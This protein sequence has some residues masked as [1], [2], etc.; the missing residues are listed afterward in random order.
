MGAER[1]SARTV[2][3]ELSGEL[4]RLRKA[5][6]LT[7][8]ALARRTSYSKSSW[9]RYLNAK[10]LPPE[11]AVTAFAEAT[12][13]PP[14]SLLALRALAERSAGAGTEQGDQERPE[15]ESGDG[16]GDA[17]AGVRGD[18]QSEAPARARGEARGDA[19]T[20][21]RDEAPAQ[22]PGAGRSGG[23]AVTSAQ[24]E[25]PAPAPGTE[26]TPGPP[27]R[28]RRRRWPWAAVIGGVAALSF[29]AGFVAG[30]LPTG[31]SEAA[32]AGDLQLPGCTDFE[33]RSKD[34]QRLGC[35]VGVWT[36]AAEKVDGAYVELRWSPA[37]RAAWA[38]VTDAQVGDVARVVGPDGG[39][40]E[41]AI[42][43]DSDTYSPM[44]E[45]PYPAAV[46]ACAELLDGREICTRQGGASPLPV[47]PEDESVRDG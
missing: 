17:Q 5:S 15:G 34:P 22:T 21:T 45:A 32:Q 20:G 2:A 41:R 16:R 7:L 3:P 6:G 33:C 1:R 29:A 35:H 26:V 23:E 42:S 10:A 14:E 27:P 12:G 46:R 43:Y 8:A 28:A 31:S 38:R 18:A 39:T 13:V 9:E 44:V 11:Q 40:Q 36:A 24:A 37:C 25:V 30:W 19:P 47:E 4:R